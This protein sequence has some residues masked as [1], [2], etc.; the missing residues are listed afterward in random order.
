[1]I[2]VLEQLGAPVPSL[3]RLEETVVIDD[4]RYAARSYR[5][6]GYLATWLVEVGVVQFYDDDGNLLATLNLSR[7]L[8]P[9]KMAA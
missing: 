6:D 8:E 2:E 1:V 9:L 7:K 3:F 5:V 4:G